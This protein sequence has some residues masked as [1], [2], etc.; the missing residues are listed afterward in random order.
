[1]DVGV[2]ADDVNAAA[3]GGR[4]KLRV[5]IGKSEKFARVGG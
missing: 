2:K 1:M 5:W 4:R 3:V